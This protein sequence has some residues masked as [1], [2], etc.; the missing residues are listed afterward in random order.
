MKS[1][2]LY[3]PLQGPLPYVLHPGFE[4]ILSRLAE[5]QGRAWALAGAD[6]RQKLR[7][8]SPDW[9]GDQRQRMRFILACLAG[10]K[11]GGTPR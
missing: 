6:V 9:P 4:P 10:A 11:L 2:S 3:R 5:V 7:I 1:T 8:H